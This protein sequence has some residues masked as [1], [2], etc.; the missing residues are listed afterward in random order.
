METAFT[1][2]AHVA[3]PL[4]WWA[5]VSV[6]EPGAGRGGQQSRWTG[7]DPAAVLTYV[8][9]YEYR[10]GLR[11]IKSLTTGPWGS[12]HSSRRAT[13]HIWNR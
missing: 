5:D 9:G 2:Q 3:V 8:H 10:A 1:R 11:Y 13:R 4:I 12:T 6:F 7:R